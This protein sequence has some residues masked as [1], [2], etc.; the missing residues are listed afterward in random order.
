MDGD[1]IRFFR[2]LPDPTKVYSKPKGL[3]Y[4]QYPHPKEK[5]LHFSVD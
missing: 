5:L 1:Q 4:S 2:Q 3:A